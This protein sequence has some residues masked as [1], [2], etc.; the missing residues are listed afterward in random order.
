MVH[1]P[2]FGYRI[3]G[4]P[5]RWSGWR[6]YTLAGEVNDGNAFHAW[7]GVAGH[8]GLFSTAGELRVLIQLLLNGG[9][10]GGR[11]YVDGDVIDVFLTST[12]EGQALGWQ[13]P[14]NAPEGSFTHTGFTGTFV[15][16]APSTGLAVVL[17]TN[18]QTEVWTPREPTLTWRPYSAPW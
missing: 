15:F 14:A 8:A 11:R 5:D 2:D 18:R 12:G 9:E 10:H 7:D 3:E 17:L 16:G 6:E 13:V 4:D 1:D